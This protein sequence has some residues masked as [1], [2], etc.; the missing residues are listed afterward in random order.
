V[1][2]EIQKNMSKLKKLL[3]RGIRSYGPLENDQAIL[4]FDNPVTVIVGQ[5]GSGKTTIIE[6]LKYMTTGEFPP[7]SK[8]GAFIMDP[9]LSDCREVQAVIKLKFT[10]VN[11]DEIVCHR[12]LQSVQKATK[13]EQKQL[14]GSMERIEAATGKKTKITSRCA[15]INAEMVYNLGVSKAI[16]NHVIF[17]HQEESNWPLSEGK[18]LKT[19]FD[20]IFASTR[21][22]KALDTI[23]KFQGEQRQQCKEYTVEL[24]YLKELK[25]KSDELKENLKETQRSLDAINVEINRINNER[26]PVEKKIKVLK[27]K[28]DRV[29][30][31]DKAIST[32]SAS[33][34]ESEKH[35]ELLKS[36]ISQLFTGSLEELQNVY[37]QHDFSLKR[38]QQNLE[39]CELSLQHLSNEEN[40]LKSQINKLSEEC[41]RLESDERHY[42]QVIKGR[43]SKISQ[44]ARYL[45]IDG[46]PAGRS[47]S[48]E[49]VRQFMSEIFQHNELKKEQLDREKMKLVEK[50]NGLQTILNELQDNCSRL[51]QKK[52]MKEKQIK[53][54]EKQ[55]TSLSRQLAR[56]AT[57]HND[58]ELIDIELK[59]AEEELKEYTDNYDITQL[60]SQLGEL[61]KTKRDQG[62]SLRA[63]QVEMNTITQQS[64]IRGAIENMKKSKQLKEQQYQKDYGEVEAELLTVVGYMPSDE[65]LDSSIIELEKSN[66]LDLTQ[67]Q[68][69][70]SKWSTDLSR[71]QALLDEKSHQLKD[72]KEQ[73]QDIESNVESVCG[74]VPFDVKLKEVKDDMSTK[75]DNLSAIKGSESYFKECLNKAKSSRKCPLCAR[76]YDNNEGL[77]NLITSI[78][79]R[80]HSKVPELIKS[81][82]QQMKQLQD[83]HQRMLELAPQLN[84]AKSLRSKEIPALEK[85]LHDKENALK[86]LQNGVKEAESKLSTHQEHLTHLRKLHPQAV[87][88]T[89]LQ[90]DLNN[91]DRDI[92]T[93]LSKLGGGNMRSHSLVQR[94]LQ[95]AQMQSEELGRKMD[96]KRNEIA[97]SQKTI[98]EL[99]NK[100]HRLKKDQL[101]LQQQVQ[102]RQTYISKKDE[103]TSGNQTLQRDINATSCQ[104]KPLEEKI[105]K[106]KREKETLSKEREE[107]ELE[108]QKELNQLQNNIDSLQ[109]WTRDISRYE[110]KQISSSLASCKSSLKDLNDKVK[111][112]LKEKQD[113]NDRRES[114]MKSLTNAKLRQRELEDNLA[115]IK[116]QLQVR[117]EQRHIAEMKDQLRSEGLDQYT[118]ELKKLNEQSDQYS[119]QLGL[120]RGRLL[121]KE[122][123]KRMIEKD[124]QTEM[125]IN[126][127]KNFRE[128]SI[129][130][131][132][133]ELAII[134]MD[135]YYKAL[136]R[137]II[138]FHTLKMNEVNKIINELWVKTY[139]GG[140]I[141]TIEIRSNDDPE[142]SASIGRRVYDY[143]VVMV[144]DDI[145]MDMRGRCSAGQKVLASIIIRLALAESFCISCGM[146]S[147]DEPTTNLDKENIEGLAEAL[148][149]IIRDRHQQKNFHLIIITHDWKFVELLGR[150]EFV[151]E[152]YR[153]SKEKGTCSTVE[154]YS[155]SGGHNYS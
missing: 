37:E 89:Q 135:K 10:N 103:L 99:E 131:K 60:E 150:S 108:N 138:R 51:K 43:D 109:G 73:L 75:E 52:E 11:G 33:I 149:D 49:S 95:K 45:A 105:L 38:N 1:E 146:L 72:K 111:L 56:I 86:K 114:L 125:Y 28:F 5:N 148:A 50:E 42:Q 55:I 136:D 64:S 58:I 4:A 18:A 54:N 84:Q 155:I 137:A 144:K 35:Q 59:Q 123:E 100:V 68:K 77:N 47:F 154:R 124:L 116:S 92:N 76:G 46:Y 61:E 82:Q 110:S 2:L 14:D 143:K 78:E 122:G 71:L 118:E 119:R 24:T 134:D 87:R 129:N 8:G 48:N 15:E 7:N 27:A 97:S 74:N 132:T 98:R 62:E 44:V 29:A 128:M 127:D 70:H 152:Y 126:A 80:L 93:E 85:E 66:Q 57:A 20:E 81:Y 145:A 140:D 112:K 13:I 30:E 19:K 32:K 53:D 79:R 139:K 121:G 39:E 107:T 120:C 96:N 21:Y 22:S 102:E 101:T 153:V 16:L 23:K 31:L 151:D 9:K 65:D 91:L 40:Q 69:N 104:L 106:T 63:L 141:D 36:N 34:K 67:V 41:G 12:V 88:L 3:I 6:C 90:K 133:T 113:Y 94:E 115:L 17:C 25:T 83:V 130:L 26:S 117:E 147:L 142:G